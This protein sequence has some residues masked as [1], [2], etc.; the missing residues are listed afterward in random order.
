MMMHLFD[1]ASSLIG[2]VGV[3]RGMVLVGAMQIGLGP[4]SSAQ[5]QNGGVMCAF[6]GYEGE[7]VPMPDGSTYDIK[8]VGDV[9]FALHYDEPSDAALLLS[10]DY[11]DPGA[12]VV[13]DSIDAGNVWNMQVADQTIYLNI[14]D[15][16]MIRRID[17]SDPSVLT[18]IDPIEL[19]EEVQQFEVH[20]DRLYCFDRQS[21]VQILDISDPSSPVE[22]G[23]FSYGQGEIE[24]FAASAD[25]L[26]VTTSEDELEV[27]DTSDPGSLVR[28]AEYAHEIIGDVRIERDQDVLLL[29]NNY[30][31]F[32]VFRLEPGGDEIV[33]Q[34]DGHISDLV[35]GFGFPSVDSVE[36]RNG[37]LTYG[38]DNYVMMSISLELL[39]DPRLIGFTSLPGEEWLV[40]GH[41]D[42][43]AVLATRGELGIS[44]VMLSEMGAVSPISEGWNAFDNIEFFDYFLD[45][46]I[47]IEGGVLFAPIALDDFV[48]RERTS[49]VAFDVTYPANPVPLGIYEHGLGEYVEIRHM[50]AR[51]SIVFYAARDYGLDIVDFSNPMQPE[52]V[53]LYKAFRDVLDMKL[54]GDILWMQV[55]DFEHVLLD[56]S[57]V[58]DIRIKAYYTMRSDEHQSAMFSDGRLY[59][60]HNDEVGDDIVSLLSVIEFSDPFRPVRVDYPAVDLFDEMSIHGGVLYGFNKIDDIMYTSPISDLKQFGSVPS[61]GKGRNVQVIDGHAYWIADFD[62]LAVFDVS[63]PYAPGLVGVLPRIHDYSSIAHDDGVMMLVG[64]LWTY[65]V[66]LSMDCDTG[67]LADVN[68]DGMLNFFDVAAMLQ[69]YFDGD[70]SVDFNNDLGV[71]F[72]DVSLFLQVY[73]SGCP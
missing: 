28:V 4:C 56:V 3:V 67:C 60:S 66:D 62:R 63:D 17:V 53:L 34:W 42:S 71:D 29:R 69:A 61:F 40:V 27:Y 48:T 38:F 19:Q 55:D 1:R 12:P 8:V 2:C 24:D 68:N 41:T 10:I 73:S 14:D 50:E 47:Q 65:T 16:P 25:R 20:G 9:A 5:A 59:I 11:R 45:A 30:R 57:D 58:H 22:I 54:D 39:D 52:R 21:V 51:D 26:Y 64:E 70:P 32:E 13:L 31:S 35:D 72:R 7:F 43:G 15:V 37:V 44:S 18:A 49:I 6:G 46:D 23:Q 36:L 33:H